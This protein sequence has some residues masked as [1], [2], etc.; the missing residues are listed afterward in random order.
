MKQEKSF[1]FEEVFKQNERRIYYNLHK[2]GIRDYYGEYYSEAMFAMWIAYKKYDRDEGPL[3]TYFN[4]AIRNRLID[5]IRKKTREY[6]VEKEYIEQE[7][8]LLIAEMN[9][10]YTSSDTNIPDEKLWK[11]VFSTLTTNQRKWVYYAIILDYPVKEIAEK[12]D[13]SVE[14]VKSWGKEAR[15]KLRRLWEMGRDIL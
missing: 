8:V 7:A 15:K 2:L 4:Y 14:A 10:T 1:T 11:N 3:S 13:V 6:E 9:S 12:E 5:L